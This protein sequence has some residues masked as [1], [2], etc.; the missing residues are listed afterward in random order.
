MLTGRTTMNTM[1]DAGSATL[2]DS[3]FV[4]TI[5]ARIAGLERTR[6]QARQVARTARRVF[7][8]TIRMRRV[9][10]LPVRQVQSLKPLDRVMV[11]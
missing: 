10:V 2:A 6:Q 11:R 1:I 4:K 5:N 8:M 9:N 7:T 3:L